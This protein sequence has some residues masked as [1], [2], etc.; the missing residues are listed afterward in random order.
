MK[1]MK[2]IKILKNI[3]NHRVLKLN[4]VNKKKLNLIILRNYSQLKFKKVK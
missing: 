1:K 4:L 2:K 3:I